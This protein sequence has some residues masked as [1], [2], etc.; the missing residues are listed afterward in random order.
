VLPFERR[1]DWR[2]RARGFVEQTVWNA[3]VCAR[4]TYLMRAE[5]LHTG[6]EN[7][8]RNFAAGRLWIPLV[9]DAELVAAEDQAR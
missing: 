5:N 9:E 1:R 8:P 2:T 7:R 6:V 3:L 4:K